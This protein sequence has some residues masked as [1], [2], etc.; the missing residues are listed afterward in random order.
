MF[1]KIGFQVAQDIIYWSNKNKKHRNTIST[2]ALLTSVYFFI[3]SFEKRDISIRH[4]GIID[5]DDDDS[6]N[7][8]DVY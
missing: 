8:F 3:I 7:N 4:L 1:N 6:N 5:D 2:Y